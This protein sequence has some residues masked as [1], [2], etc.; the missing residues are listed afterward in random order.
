[1]IKYIYKI[2]CK[3]ESVNLQKKK[4]KTKYACF[5]PVAPDWFWS[6]F[7][8][9]FISQSQVFIIWEIC[10]ISLSAFV[11]PR[12]CTVLIKK[13]HC[14]S[15]AMRFKLFSCILLTFIINTIYHNQLYQYLLNVFALVH[16]Q[17]SIPSYIQLGGPHFHVLLWLR[18]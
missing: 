7:L 1:M 5:P 17:E 18:R 11:F 15:K 16:L 10:I 3:E 2:K 4:D 13:L 9:M 12:F 14:C 6:I 8:L